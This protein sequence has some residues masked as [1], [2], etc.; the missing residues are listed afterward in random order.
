MDYFIFA[1]LG[2]SQYKIDEIGHGRR[3]IRNYVMLSQ[4]QSRLNPNSVWSNFNSVGMVES[5]R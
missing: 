3:E 2:C 4:I 5:I 1:K